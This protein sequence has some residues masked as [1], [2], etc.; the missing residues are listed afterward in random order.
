MKKNK[1][2]NVKI[3][4]TNNKQIN[5]RKNKTWKTQFK[6]SIYIKKLMKT[7]KAKWNFKQLFINKQ[8]KNK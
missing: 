4:Q 1:E 6:I 8:I 7:N 2:K 3:Q 5:E